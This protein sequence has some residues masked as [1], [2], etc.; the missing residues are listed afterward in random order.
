MAQLEKQC[1]RARYQCG[2]IGLTFALGWEAELLY[3]EL[4]P[5]GS[6]TESWDEAAAF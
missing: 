5:L 3:T 6:K 1:K 4:L 2:T